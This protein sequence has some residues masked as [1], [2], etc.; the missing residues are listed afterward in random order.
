MFF[1]KIK[2]RFMNIYNRKYKKEILKSDVEHM[3]LLHIMYYEEY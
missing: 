2:K 3:F 1:I